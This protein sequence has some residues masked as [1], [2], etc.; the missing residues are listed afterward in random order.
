VQGAENTRGSFAENGHYL[1]FQDSWKALPRLTVTLGVRYEYRGPWSD[2]R[3]FM[4]NFNLATGVLDPP[5]Q[6]LNLQ[7]WET[8]R[9]QPDVPLLRWNKKGILPR[10]GVAYRLTSK[11]VIRSGYG[12]YADEPSL[13]MIQFL[14]NN[15]RPNAA[16]KT[17]RADPTIPSLTLSDP[18]N[19]AALVPGGGLPDVYGFQSPL[20]QWL[21]HSWGFAIQRELSPNTVFEIGYQGS[22]TVHEEQIVS[23]NDATPGTTPRQQRR[24]YPDYQ[25]ITMVLG[26][27][28]SRYNGLE[29][30]L[31]RRPGKAGLSL[32]LAYTWAK[33]IDT[34]GGRF[35]KVGDQFSISRN[36]N[37]QSNRG[38]GEANIPS[39]FAMMGGY[40]LPFGKGKPFF[41][42]SPLGKILGGWSLNGILT[43]QA[44]PYITPVMPSDTLDAGSTAS[45]RP[46]VLRNPNLGSSQ[47]SIQRWFDTSAFV[48]PSPFKYGNAGRSIIQAPGIFNLDT[49]LLRSFSTTETS[50]LEFRFEAFNALN[51]A[52]FTF[53][54]TTFGTPTFGVIGGTF[55]AR[56]LQFG[57]KFYF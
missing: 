51:H 7:A 41:S 21:V 39:R 50:H 17:F 32:M 52:N 26:N 6:N 10:I 25:N 57:L 36:V 8:G 56:D 30:K 5:L 27:G 42:A 40:E 34:V 47:R 49:G 15:P 11:T 35:S 3:G 29:M 22:H 43:L 20:P 24:P 33:E 12:I 45:F 18:F 28:D 38:L 53:P 9:F 14:G 46:D 44:G 48:A 16:Q 13:G 1:F 2:R 55:E 37:L 54:G 23:A 19:P 4:S 31:E